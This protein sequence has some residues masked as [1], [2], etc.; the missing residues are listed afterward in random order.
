MTKKSFASQPDSR[1]FVQGFFEGD[2]PRP[3]GVTD[4]SFHVGVQGDQHELHDD[5]EKE[6]L[7]Q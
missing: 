4:Q 5:S 2:C 1:G 3:H 6:S 7:T